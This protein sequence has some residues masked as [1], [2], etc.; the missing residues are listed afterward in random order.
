M[1]LTK[2]HYIIDSQLGLTFVLLLY[3]TGDFKEVNDLGKIGHR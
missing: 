1:F 2:L 3:D